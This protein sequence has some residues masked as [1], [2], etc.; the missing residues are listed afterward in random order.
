VS[1]FQITQPVAIVDTASNTYLPA[2]QQRNRGI[3]INFFGEPAE[4]VRVLGGAMFLEPILTQTQDGLNDGWQA[5]GTPNMQLNLAGEWDLPFARG[6]TVNGRMI[7]TGAQ[8]IDTSYPRRTIPDWARFDV[9][10]R[11]TFDN[12]R[13]PTGKPVTLRFNVENLFDASYWATSFYGYLVQGTPRT[14]KLSAT[15]NF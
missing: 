2:G 11:Y 6:V 13:S 10:A 1:A 12:A 14:F 4:G 15:A 3:E 7:Y 5:F 9:G 8:Y